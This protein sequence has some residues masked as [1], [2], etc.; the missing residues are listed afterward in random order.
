MQLRDGASELERDLIE[1]LAVR[2]GVAQHEDREVMDGAY[3]GAMRSLWRKYP[4]ND[5]VGF[6]YADALICETPWD[7][8]SADFEPNVNTLEAIA[9]LEEVFELNLDHPGANHFYIHA[10]E[11]SGEAYRAEAAADRLGKITPGLG[12]MVHMPAHIYVQVGRYEDSVRCNDEGARLDREY[13]AAAGPQTIYH[14]YQAHNTHFRVWSA[15]YMGAYEE[16]LEACGILIEDLPD[17]MKGMPSTAQWLGM[18]QKVHLRFGQWQAALDEPKPREDQPYA[19]ALWH[20]G[21][22]LAYANLRRF[23]EARAEAERFEEVAASLPD[24]DMEF[25]ETVQKVM[26]IA[27]EM[28]AGEIAYLSGDHEKGFEH[29]RKAVEAEDALDYSEPSPWMVP[30]RHSLGALL[31]EQGQ[32]G[33]AE[34]HYRVDLKKHSGNVWSLQGLTECLERSGQ[35]EE[36]AE[37]RALFEAARAKATVDVSVSCFCRTWI[38]DGL[39]S[40]W[41]R[42]GAVRRAFVGSRCGP[43]S[44]ALARTPADVLDGAIVLD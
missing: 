32:L 38:P 14:G 19:V 36:A 20:Y 4:D 33:E 28:L 26:T 17:A 27:R 7:L 5:D 3:A 10:W 6:L 23:D 29:L 12:H 16:A 44:R 41:G 9:V 42:S 37:V 43:G 40:E 2:V 15:M 1:A 21:R 25:F 13:F 8:W 31:L 39:R 24:D 18:E 30:T 11:P 34:A 35:E 22:G